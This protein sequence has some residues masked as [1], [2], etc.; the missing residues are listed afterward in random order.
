MAKDDEQVSPRL[1][2]LYLINSRSELRVGWGQF[3]QAQESNELQVSD[4]VDTFIL[5]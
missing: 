5:K 3:S 1:S 4:G 2:V